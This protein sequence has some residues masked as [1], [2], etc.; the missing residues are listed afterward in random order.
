MNGEYTMHLRICF[1]T[2]S[3]MGARRIAYKNRASAEPVSSIISVVLCCRLVLRVYMVQHTTSITNSVS[4]T[5]KTTHMDQ[6]TR[7]VSKGYLL[8]ADMLQVWRMRIIRIGLNSH[9]KFAKILIECYHC[10]QFKYTTH[11]NN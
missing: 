5:N 8:E 10:L 6:I 2:Q 11:I 3:K 1:D 9:L 4:C 7:A